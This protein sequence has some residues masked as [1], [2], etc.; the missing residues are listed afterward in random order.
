[1][2]VLDP[3]AAVAAPRRREILR[4]VWDHERAA[5]EIHRAIGSISFGAVSQHL[6]T[7][8]RSGLVSVRR[9][10]Q[11]RLYRARTERL[12]PLRAYLEAMWAER[13]DALRDLAEAEVEGQS[14]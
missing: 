6:S 9:D 1:M 10:G 12:G 4:L 2:S 14:R 5:G 8:R 7:L 3:L 13:L 11:R